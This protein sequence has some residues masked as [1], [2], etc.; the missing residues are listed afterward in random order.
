MESS[1][2]SPTSETYLQIGH[3]KELNTAIQSIPT[4][5]VAGFKQMTVQPFFD[6]GTEQR[7]QLDKAHVIL[8]L[9]S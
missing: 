8:S 4:N 9:I 5:I 7:Q 2:I 3:G 1:F 6:L